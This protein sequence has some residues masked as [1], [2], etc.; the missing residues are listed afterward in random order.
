MK[1]GPCA[2]AGGSKAASEAGG[3]MWKFSRCLQSATAA[4]H[5]RDRVV[6]KSLA[7]FEIRK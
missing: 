7:C 3:H 4:V 5:G 2:P 1:S 6:L